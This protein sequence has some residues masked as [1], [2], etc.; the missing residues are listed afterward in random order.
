MYISLALM[1]SKAKKHTSKNKSPKSTD[2]TVNT[3]KPSYAIAGFVRRFAAFIY[4]GLLNIAIWMVVSALWLK[5]FYSVTGKAPEDTMA[6]QLT[7]FPLLL[8]SSFTF[9]G[10][11]WTHGGATLGMQSWRLRAVRSD[12]Q[13][14]TW[15]DAFKRYC[16][17]AVFNLIAGIGLLWCL[18]DKEKNAIQDHLSDT[19]VIFIPKE[20]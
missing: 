7:L 1:K 12:G 16:F 6:Q 8:L 3:E 11:F 20:K 17:A 19:R 18:F 2:K 15:L 9:Y 4:D 14:M 10:W 13:T 5:I